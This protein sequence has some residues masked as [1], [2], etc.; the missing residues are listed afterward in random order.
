M[1]ILQASIVF[2][3]LIITACNSHQTKEQTVV[4]GS[5]T[6]KFYPL[7]PFFKVQVQYVD[8]RN[9]FIYRTTVKDSSVLTKEQFAQ[10]ASVFFKRDISDP[11]VKILYR[12]TVFQDLSTGS[13]TLNYKST[14]SKTDVQNIDILL[15]EA[16]HIAK[17]V[18]IRSVFTRGDTTISEQ[19]NWNADK[20]FQVNRSISAKGGYHT[21]EL[22]FV[23][24]NDKP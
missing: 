13:I 4:P 21:T 7:R 3:V 12:E 17:R 24:W 1:K 6:G 5:D 9:F 20:S 18:F 23:N 2:I 22:N 14:D 16:T 11:K 8:L 15:D 10:L 19:C